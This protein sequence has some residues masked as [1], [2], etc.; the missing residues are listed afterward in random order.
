MKRA[1][2]VIL[3]IV[4]LLGLKALAE[5]TLIAYYPF[6]GN[7]NDMSGNGYNGTVYGASLTTG[8]YGQAYHFDGSNDYISAAV[9]IN[10]NNY[11]QLTMGAWVKADSGIGASAIISHDKGGF[12]RTIGIKEWNNGGL[13]WQ[14]FSGSG[15]FLTGSS[16][17]T[18]WTFIAVVYDQDKSSVMLYV[19]GNTWTETGSLGSGYDYIN[20]GR[21]P[22]FGGYFK[23]IIDDVFIYNEALTKEQLDDIYQNGI[24]PVPEPNT[25]LL[26]SSA[27]VMAFGLLRKRFKG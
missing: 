4:I 14:A 5:A 16:V 10:P 6:E 24:A 2:I 11:S 26:L 18:D 17:T 1:T 22:K 13:S 25:L 9:D 12:D 8:Y 27:G 3:G 20:I 19:D 21:N 7:A 23:G 15:Q